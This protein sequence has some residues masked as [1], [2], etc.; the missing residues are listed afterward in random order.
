MPWQE[1]RV[2]ERRPA[3]VQDHLEGMSISE[4]AEINSVSRKTIYKSL[5]RSRGRRRVIAL[6]TR[7]LLPSHFPKFLKAY[8]H[9]LS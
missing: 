2:E 8:P 5:E 3:V 6:N 9:R 4:L 7:C 1:I